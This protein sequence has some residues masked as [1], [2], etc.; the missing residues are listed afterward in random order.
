MKKVSQILLF[1]LCMLFTLSC[2]KEN[3]SKTE[4]DIMLERYKVATA[5]SIASNVSRHPFS[6]ETTEGC[7]NVTEAD[8]AGTFIWEQKDRNGDDGYVFVTPIYRNEEIIADMVGY[9]TDDNRILNAINIVKPISDNRSNY[10]VYYINGTKLSTSI[11]DN[12]EGKIIETTIETNIP[13]NTPEGQART[14]KECTSDCI[15]DCHIACYQDK[16]CMK[17]LL[18]TNV[19]GT[20]TTIGGQGT[21]SIAIACGIACMKN[22]KMDLLPQ[23]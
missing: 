15:S 14:W 2:K 23:Y 19:G 5:K 12:E 21:L 11:V 4:K 10:D 18:F 13:E 6:L 22:K 7:P 1:S 9:V 8:L 16:E 20:G 17:L 3:S